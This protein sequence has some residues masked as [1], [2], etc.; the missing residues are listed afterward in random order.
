MRERGGLSIA[1]TTDI[2]RGSPVSESCRPHFPRQTHRIPRFAN[3]LDEM[4]PRQPR[5]PWA[6]PQ[7]QQ[8]QMR[9]RAL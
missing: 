8:H 7:K 3:G 1:V 5:R 9:R 2:G 6:L 4:G